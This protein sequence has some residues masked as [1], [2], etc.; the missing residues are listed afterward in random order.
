MTEKLKSRFNERSTWVA[1]YSALTASLPSILSLEAPWN[2]LAFLAAF[3]GAFV[4]DGTV[5]APK[6]PVA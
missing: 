4:P 2:V 1:V 3:L 5:I 6:E